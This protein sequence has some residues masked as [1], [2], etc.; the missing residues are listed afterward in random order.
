MISVIGCADDPV[1][2]FATPIKVEAYSFASYRFQI[3]ALFS[4]WLVSGS[5]TYATV[6]LRR[7]NP[8]HLDFIL[9][10][11]LVSPALRNLKKPCHATVF[12]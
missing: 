3:K 6:R 2:L 9:A 11:K 7:L 4:R 10:F 1:P 12:M 5:S 8:R